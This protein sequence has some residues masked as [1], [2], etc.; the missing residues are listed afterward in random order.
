MNEQVVCT[1]KQQIQAMDQWLSQA[2]FLVGCL[3]DCLGGLG[4]WK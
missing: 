2:N 3:K 4:V 1:G